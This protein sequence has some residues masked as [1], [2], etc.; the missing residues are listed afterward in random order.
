[1]DYLLSSYYNN[2][3]CRA[4]LIGMQAIDL[5]QILQSSDLW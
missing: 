5:N 3:I 4:V 1:M 2:P